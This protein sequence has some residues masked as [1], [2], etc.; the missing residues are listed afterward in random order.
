VTIGRA[1]AALAACGL[2]L[3]CLAVPLPASAAAITPPEH[4][5]GEEQTYL[6]YPEWFLVHSPA[7]YAAYIA[8]RPP[9]RFPYLAHIGQFWQ[10]YAAVYEATRDAYPLNLGYH[11]MVMVIGVSTTVEYALKWA[12][13]SL[14]G[15]LTEALRTAPV[16]E[17]RYAA[18]RAQDYVDFIRVRPWYEFDFVD[19]LAGLWR[20]VPMLGEDLVRKWERRWALSTE[21]A[22]K[23]GY[24]WLIG[25][26]TRIGY[27]EASP[28]TAI[29]VDRLPAAARAALPA[30]S[31]LAEQP[32]PAFGPGGWVSAT[33]PRYEAFA[34]HAA[35]LAAQGANFI[36]IAGNRGP[37]L[38]SVIGTGDWSP[39]KDR[40]Q[41]LFV[42]PILT[43]PGRTRHVFTVPVDALAGALRAW[44]AA[45]VEVEHLYD[46]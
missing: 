28:V 8:D 33:V 21:Y 10:S 41:P 14:A 4:Q 35:T 39:G 25:V 5:R 15:R 13:E 9:S 36:E 22:I 44:Q 12:Y 40:V 45:G 17:D 30:L 19:A 6:T 18:R 24:G 3:A 43:R 23:A 38:V 2:A 37:I 26:A 34:G 32:V 31:V 20:E 27:E 16:A 7:E 1:R 42:Q 46:Y 11:V 29:V